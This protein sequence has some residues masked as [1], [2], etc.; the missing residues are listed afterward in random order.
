[1]LSNDYAPI[2]PII[3]IHRSRFYL[4]RAASARGCQPG[5]RRGRLH[6]H[7]RPQRRR[8]DDPAQAHAGAA[9]TA[10]RTDPGHGRA[11]RARLPPHRLC[12]P[13]CTHQPALSHY[14][15][16]RRAHG[17][18]GPGK[19]WS[20]NNDRTGGMPWRPWTASI[21]P[22]TPIAAS[23]NCP[24]ASASGCSSPGPW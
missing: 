24:A 17:Q 13:G 11:G 4:Q 23:V 20:K 10:E 3:Q 22:G 7:D 6:R 1:M 15:P 12:P 14:G 2:D 16:G 5:G 19:R 8:Q 9:Q 21:W 18:T